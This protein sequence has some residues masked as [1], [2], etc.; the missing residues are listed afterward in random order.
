[1]IKFLC[2]DMKLLILTLLLIVSTNAWSQNDSIII[3]CEFLKHEVVDS[4]DLS[5]SIKFS[6]RSKQSQM[7]YSFFRMGGFDDEDANIYIKVEKLKDS[8]YSYYPLGYYRKYNIP[9]K[10]TFCHDL[11][12]TL[13]RAFSA[14]TL[15]YN[16]MMIGTYFEVGKYRFKVYV[17]KKC[18]LIL[19]KSE[20]DVEY[21]RVNYF[22][23]DWYHLDVK[24]SI[25]SL[26]F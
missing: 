22:I 10:D 25:Y 8:N 19:P 16:L 1:M 2:L 12:K 17:R 4:A 23:S 5:F 18:Q 3:S 24:K 20:Y 14:K 26:K 9:R 7:V 15:T 21:S 6:N 11:S 13:L